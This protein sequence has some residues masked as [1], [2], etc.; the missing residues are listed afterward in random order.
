[1]LKTFTLNTICSLS[2]LVSCVSIHSSLFKF[3][4]IIVLFS[5]GL[6]HILS[7]C[8]IK[9]VDLLETRNGD[10]L[11]KIVNGIQKGLCIQ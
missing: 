5:F 10:S 11:K 2:L 7:F 8:R 3:C 6:F 4:F 9:R 1:M